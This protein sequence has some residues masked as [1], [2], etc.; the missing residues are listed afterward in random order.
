M[1]PIATNGVGMAVGAALLAGASVVAGEAWTIPD[2]GVTWAATAWLVLAGSVGMFWLFLLVVQRWTASASAYIT[3]LMPVVAVALAAVLTDEAI[4]LEEVVGGLLV[5]AGAYVGT[6]Q[7][8]APADELAVA[9]PV[10]RS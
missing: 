1:D 10:A 9:A 8:R 7:R 2:T 4:G 5:I 6:L 3:P